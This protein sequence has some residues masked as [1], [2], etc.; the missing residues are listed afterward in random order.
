MTIVDKASESSD[1]PAYQNQPGSSE[2]AS[3]GDMDAG[4]AS[5]GA[6]SSLNDVSNHTLSLGPVPG[7]VVYSSSSVP[8]KSKP[9]PQKDQ[10]LGDGIAPPQ[11]VLFP[12]EKICLKWQQTHRVGA[13]LQNLGN[14][15]FANAALQCLTYTPPLANY[16]LSH[17][18]SKTCHAE[19]FC[20]MCTMQAHITQAL[21]N[22]GDVIKPMFVINEMRRIARHFRFGNQ[23]DAHEFLQY[24][25]D[26]MQKACLNGSNKL[27]RHT[28]ATTLVCQIFGGYLRS[29]VKCL[30]CKGVSDTFDPYLDITLEIKAAQSVNKALEQFVKPEQLDGENSYKCSKCKKM[31]PASKRFTIHRSSNVLTLSL[32]RFANFTGGKI[33]KDVKYPEYLDIRPYMS[34]PNGEP[35][36]YVLYAVLVHTGFNCHAGH[37]FC[38]IKASNG[39][40]YQMNDSI[41]S[42]SDIRSVLSQQAYVLFYIRSHDVKNGGELTHSTHSPGQSS[43]RPVISQRVVSNKQAASGF[44]GPQLPSHVIKNPPHLNGTGPLKEAPSSSMSSPSGNSSV[45]RAGSVN[46]STSVQNWSVNRPSVIPEHPKKQKITISI[47]NKL[48]VRQGQSQPSLHG[49][50]LDTPSKPVPSSTVTSSAM[51]STSSASMTAV[52]SKVTKQMTPSESCSKPV[53]NG[54]SKLRS[55]VLVPYGAESSEE[56]D[57]EAKGLGK[58]NGLGTIES[59][60]S[61]VQDAEDDEASP[62]ELREPVALN[63]ADSPDSDLKENGL[64]CDGAR[65]PVQPA[66]H[67]ENPFSKANGLPGKS[68]PAPLPPLPEDNI[69]ETFKLGSKV[70]GATEETS[71]PGTEEG[72]AEGP[73]A[74]LEPGS[75]SPDS[76]EKPET[77]TSLS[78]K[79]KKASPPSDPSIQS[80]KEEVSEN[81]AAK[82]EEF[83]PGADDLCGSTRNGAGDDPLPKPCGP[84]DLTDDQSRPAQAASGTRTDSPL[85]SAVVEAAQGSSPS[86]PARSEGACEHEPF[87][88]T[89]DKRADT[90]TEGPWKGAGAAAADLP[91]PQVDTGTE[92]RSEGGP[93]QSHGEKREE[94]KVGQKVPDRSPVKEKISILRRVDRGHYRNRRDRS[95]SGERAR[96]SRSKTEDR[97]HRKRRSYTRERPR[98]DRY[99]TEH[100]GGS[101][102]HP[103]HGERASPGEPRS[104]ARY[105]HHHPRSRGGSEQEWGRYHHSEGEH[106]WA[107]EK[108]YPE[109]LR[110]DKCRYYHDRYALYAAREWRPFHERP[111]DK[112]AA[113]GRPYRDCYRSRKGCEAA[114]KGKG[115]HRFS[116][117][118]GPPPAP[119]PYPEKHPHEKLAPGAEDDTCDLAGRFHD[120]EN[121][122]SRKRRY[123]SLE[124]GDGRGEK[125]AWRG[126]Q[127]EPLEEPKAKKHKKSKKKKKSKDKHRDRDSRHQQD[128]DLSVACSDADLHRHKKKKKKKKRHSRKSEDF[129]KDS[130][131]H[132]PKAASHETVDRFRRTDGAFPLTDGLPLEGVGPFCEK[133][134]HLRMGSRDDRCP[135]SEC[136]QGK[137]RYL[138]LRI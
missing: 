89:G 44:M 29:R 3:P 121:V 27:D 12:S 127:K 47:H 54:K 61:S 15:C 103:C 99:R 46:A 68:M 105:G 107:R 34:Q 80:T 20:M 17:E 132:L 13:G 11:K 53:M 31:V 82:P 56:S 49:P 122:K 4:S 117:R 40:W 76:R 77:L 79:L 19:G 70:K 112:A 111:Y 43:P 97:Y 136:G 123:D 42:T 10:A 87:C 88:V 39:L 91:S 108:Y 84:G 32:K 110:W 104:L 125:R 21:S 81:I 18:H 134:K 55:S 85:A 137:R 83:S 14:T 26:A 7:A 73:G 30:N 9:S 124:N 1:P 64:P 96:E 138:E 129:V 131:P 74:E 75:P 101:Q 90:D 72:P 114:A 45:S 120:H 38:Y 35:I 135:L 102:H 119:L 69:L 126:A 115:R 133:R 33:A 22:P 24:T 118:A 48:P 36:I 93:E 28:Q 52:S 16:M 63:G 2:A 95:S 106:P 92:H 37:Y 50:S 71:S 128:S 25:V 116:P 100:C 65:C 5:W 98:Q 6:V 66:L 113:A 8:D 109:K 51:Q 59:S 41:V 58:E 130:E 86:P 60:N 94:N 62:L 78:S 67:S 57:E 23:E